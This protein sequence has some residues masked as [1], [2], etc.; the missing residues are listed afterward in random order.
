MSLPTARA[1]EA[2]GPGAPRAK[3]VASSAPRDPG[4]TP[5]PPTAP[6]GADELAALA[7]SLT[8]SICSV[9]LGKEDEARTAVATFLAGG[10][11]L[12]EDV[13]G[14]GKTT[15][16]LALARCL[17]LRSARIQFTA[18]LLPA[19]VTGVSIYDQA[20][21][22]FRFHPGP[23][24]TGILI[25]DEI[26]RA[27]PRT[28]SALLEAMGE[29]HVSVEGRSRPLPD[30]FMTVGTQNPLDMEGTFPLPEAQRDRFMTRLSLGYPDPEAETAMVL[31]RGGADPLTSLTP[32]DTE[33]GARRARAA[34]AA[35][36]VTRPV[37]RYAVALAAAT[38]DTSELILGASPRAALHLV[39]M[40]RAGAAMDGRGFVTPDDIASAAP[41]VLGHRIVPAGRFASTAHERQAAE[42]VLARIIARAPAPRT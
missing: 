26:N 39:A 9:V 36:A 41:A 2:P 29:G 37:A 21:R 35:I 28:Q 4:S 23:V 5:P 22:A 18:D 17:G 27:T 12:I 33:A 3:A 31:A 11:L 15:L 25:A 13:P 10:H 14:V 20:A 40:G 6:M 7:R 24:F 42:S 30:P 34:V 1:P 32:V 8:A 19:D 16:A 38:R